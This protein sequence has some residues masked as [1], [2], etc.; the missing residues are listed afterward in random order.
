MF[1]ASPMSSPPGRARSHFDQEHEHERTQFLLRAR[2]PC[3]PGRD[4]QH[5][6]TASMKIW[7]ITGCSSGLGKHIANAV[8]ARGDALVATARDPATLRDLADRFPNR[9][10]TAMLDVTRPHS[11]AA[12]VALAKQEFG[13]LDV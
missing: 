1:P 6:R 11:A 7:L 2:R 3:R 4:E 12:A 9:V 5:K 10:R 13:G 8:A